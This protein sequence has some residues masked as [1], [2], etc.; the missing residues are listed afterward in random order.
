ME[1]TQMSIDWWM[2][3]EVVVY[4]QNGILFSHQKEW[5]FA[6]LNNMD[7]AR[8]YYDKWNKSEK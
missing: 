8:V 3:K 1:R 4:V 6:I 7:G 2:D 5:N